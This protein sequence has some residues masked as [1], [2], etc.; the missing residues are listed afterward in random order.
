LYNANLTSTD[1]FRLAASVEGIDYAANCEMIEN[2]NLITGL[3]QL[4][5]HQPDNS[6]HLKLANLSIKNNP[7]MLETMISTDRLNEQ[8]MPI[9]L[10]MKLLVDQ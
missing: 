7:S 3:C 10:A 2:M 9:A 1:P 8:N 6:I 5:L 4:Q